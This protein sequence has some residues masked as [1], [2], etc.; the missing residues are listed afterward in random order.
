MV[1]ALDEWCKCVPVLP[2]DGSWR[3]TAAEME[4][5][6]GVDRSRRRV[7]DL[8]GVCP[9]TS[10]PAAVA[11]GRVLALAARAFFAVVPITVDMKAPQ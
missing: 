7:P 5:M 3:L 6:A 10:H 8:L 4:A 11:L 2:A 1:E 9:E